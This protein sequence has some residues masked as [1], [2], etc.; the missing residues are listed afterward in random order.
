MGVILIRFRNVAALLL[1]P[2]LALAQSAAL[3][4][5]T[6]YISAKKTTG[7]FRW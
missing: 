5:G 1:L 7:S 2:A 3:P 6:S 4:V